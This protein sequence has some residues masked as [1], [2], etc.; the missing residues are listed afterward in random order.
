MVKDQKVLPE[1]VEKLVSFMEET[2]G[3]IEDYVRLN[4][5]YTNVDSAALIRE[6]YK[7]TKPHLDSEDV[8]LLL[9]DSHPPKPVSYTH[10]TLPTIPLV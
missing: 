1:N 2:N 4:A 6:Y 8:S 7:Q 3:S 5:D 9:E 10:L